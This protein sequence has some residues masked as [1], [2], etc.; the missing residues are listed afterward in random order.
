MTFRLIL[1]QVS[2]KCHGDQVS[3]DSDSTASALCPSRLSPPGDQMP[4]AVSKPL[5]QKKP[6]MESSDWFRLGHMAFPESMD[7]RKLKL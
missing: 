3:P 7:Q 1:I 2:H 5:G 4:P 6:L